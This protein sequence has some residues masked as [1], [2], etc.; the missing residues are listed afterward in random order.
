MIKKPL[1]IQ[2]YLDPETHLVHK[3]NKHWV[4]DIEAKERYDKH[5]NDEM[6]EKYISYHKRIFDTFIGI[7]MKNGS[8]LDFGC[9]ESI[10]QKRFI[11]DLVGYDLY[12]H[13]DPIVLE[14]TYDSIILIEVVEHFQD[15]VGEFQKLFNLLKPG[16]RLLIQTQFY[17]DIDELNRWW[18][19]RDVTHVVFYQYA[20]FEY[21]ANR[22]G[23]SIIYSDYKSRIVLEKRQ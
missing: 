7:Y 10:I 22:F 23:F 14:S 1:P 18:Y 16:G 2:F 15:P 8:I 11:P 21:I 4:S 12:Y 6:D 3:A 9:G 19:T 17:P 20:A 13:N 5:H